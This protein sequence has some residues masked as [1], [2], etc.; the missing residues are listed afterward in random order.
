MS[1]LEKRI[2]TAQGLDDSD[3]VRVAVFGS[4]Y[5]GYYV[6]SELLTPELR[7]WVTVVGVATDDPTHP[8]VSPQKRVW[9]YPH[10]Q[11]ER[12]MVA[13]LAQQAGLDVY[14]GPVKTPAFYEM[15]EQHWKPDLCIMATFGQRID[16]RLYRTPCLGFYNLHPCV[17]DGWPSRYAGSNPFQALLDDGHDHVVIALHCVDDGFDT[18][19]L[20]AYSEP[21]PMPPHVNVTDLH[22]ITSPTAGKFAATS[23]MRLI[24]RARAKT[25]TKT[26]SQGSGL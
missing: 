14:K 10:T 5:R 17:A 13:A 3:L 18:G 15:F 22:K 21:I 25:K 11:A 6:L 26:N 12:D 9:Q 24:Q 23:I 1:A 4:F 8:F 7:A 16:A 20:V 2:L 19:A